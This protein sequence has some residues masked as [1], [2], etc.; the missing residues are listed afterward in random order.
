PT[1]LAFVGFWYLLCLIVGRRATYSFATVSSH[2]GNYSVVYITTPSSDEAESLASALVAKELAACVNVLP[3]VTSVYGWEG[4]VRKDPESLM[5]VKTR[6][7]LLPEL[8]DY[9]ASNHPYSVPE[10]LAVPVIGGLSKY[11]DWVHR[12]TGGL[13]P[14]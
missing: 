3:S 11:L 14:T 9:V 4:Q 1:F 8:A 13:R 2:H 7:A 12:A 6:L 5:I 10:V